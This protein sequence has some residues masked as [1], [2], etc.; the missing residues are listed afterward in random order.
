M[1]SGSGMESTVS[2]ASMPPRAAMPRPVP[3]NS[4]PGRGGIKVWECAV[5]GMGGEGIG[6]HAW[7]MRMGGGLW[8]KPTEPWMDDAWDGMGEQ[9][10]RQEEPW[11]KEAQCDV[12]VADNIDHPTQKSSPPLSLPFSSLS[13]SLPPFL[14]P[15]P[16]SPFSSSCP[17]APRTSNS[18][19]APWATAHSTSR[20]SSSPC[21][22]SPFSPFSP[23]SLSDPLPSPAPHLSLF[24]P[25]RTVSPPVCPAASPPASSPSP[26]SRRNTS[27]IIASVTAHPFPPISGAQGRGA[28]AGEAAEEGGGCR[29]GRRARRMRRS[30][31]SSLRGE[32]GA[33]GGE[34][35][36]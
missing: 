3:G 15:L 33:R 11:R 28:G 25:S 7:W 12:T 20:L 32:T 14:S 16:L 9:H 34:A 29:R 17:R 10:I 30:D 36:K 24:P 19:V 27:P 18:H 22:S 4:A 31:W 2:P 6:N 5:W 13:A 1:M 26:P 35:R 8:R 21:P 23:S